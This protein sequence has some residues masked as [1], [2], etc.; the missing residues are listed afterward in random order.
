MTI[1]RA[2]QYLSRTQAA[3]LAGVTPRTIKRWAVKG[4]LTTYRDVLSGRVKYSQQELRKIME[5]R[6]GG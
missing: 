5:N 4:A 3:E 1:S 2:Q 6:P